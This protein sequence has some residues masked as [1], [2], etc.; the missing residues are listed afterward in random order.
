[1]SRLHNLNI[2]HGHPLTRNIVVNEKRQVRLIDFKFA[3]RK[4]IDWNN[5][6]SIW[7]AFEYDYRKLSNTAYYFGLTEIETLDFFRSLLQKYV[8]IKTEKIRIELFEQ[9]R[10]K[11]FYKD[12]TIN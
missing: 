7:N 8:K 10:K 12:S 5:A 11:L 2:K 6:Q 4:Q 9:I 3:E 1:M